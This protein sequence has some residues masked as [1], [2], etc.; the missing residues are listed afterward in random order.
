MGDIGP[1]RAP[2]LS[3]RGQHQL[4]TSGSA[5]LFAKES[6]SDV[7][8]PETN[9]EGL[10]NFG[11]AEN[12]LMIDELS[13]YFEKHFKLSPKD[14]V[15]A[16][17]IS[18]TTRLLS[19][20]CSFVNEHFNP[21][22]SIIDAPKPRHHRPQ[23]PV[24]GPLIIDH[25][26]AG[27]GAGVLISQFIRA[28]ADSGDGVL[29]A[30]PYYGAFD[31]D[32]KLM[33]DVKCVGVKM[34]RP[35]AARSDQGDRGSQKHE[36]EENFTMKEV[37]RME[38][39][40]KKSE[41]EGINIKAVILCN[42]HNPLGRCYPRDVIIAYAQFC[43]RHNLH[44][45]SDE[46]YAFSLYEAK[47]HLS[48]PQ[49]RRPGFVSVLSFDW[50]KEHAVDPARIHVI[51][52]MSKDFHSN[53][54]RAGVLISPFNPNLVLSIMT[55]SP[56]MMTSTPADLLW[57][58][59]LKNKEW[60]AWFLKENKGR[61]RE[62]YELM[63]GWLDRHGVGHIPAYAGQFLVANL[64]PFLTESEANR[65]LLDAL[66]VRTDATMLERESALILYGVRR[67]RVHLASG[68]AFHMP[69]AGWVRITFSV[70]KKRCLVGLRRIEKMMGWKETPIL[71]GFG[72]PATE[73]EDI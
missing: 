16:D 23:N 26:L 21:H 6:R 32:V 71:E 69:E 24:E 15:Y 56:F 5:V 42:P 1:N 62:A 12:G 53:G 36:V 11:L 63:T 59:I 49:D 57:S 67:Y 4:E 58:S 43:E 48:I 18:G 61:L 9:P 20:I 39:V 33:N 44:L 41:S 68:S 35:I 25:F 52:G 37:E 40:L 66:H 30:E 17:H 60:T 72:W 19:G 29:V 13:S 7:Y 28:I 47:D 34:S 50:R 38:E 27:S 10:I 55:T 31:R 46:I 45:L 14:Y 54:F 8:D 51:Y 70:E 22:P 64:R 2:L 73:K 65:P 3:T